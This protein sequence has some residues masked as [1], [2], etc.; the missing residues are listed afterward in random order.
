MNRSKMSSLL[1]RVIFLL[2][3]LG[4]TLQTACSRRGGSGASVDRFAIEIEARLVHLPIRGVQVERSKG[5]SQVTGTGGVFRCFLAEEISFS[6]AGLYLGSSACSDFV[7][8][9]SLL[10][11]KNISG[12]SLAKVSSIIQTFAV[13]IPATGPAEELDLGPGREALIAIEHADWNAS[14]Y[15][16]AAFVAT[17]DAILTAAKGAAPVTE[18]AAFQAQTVQSPTDA[19]VESSQKSRTKV[20]ELNDEM[21]S[22]HRA[23]LQAVALS[24]PGDITARAKLIPAS[25][26]GCREEYVFDLNLKTI[27]LGSRDLFQIEGFTS[28]TSLGED[29]GLEG[30][31]TATPIFGVQA[32]TS[33][34][35][36]E[37]ETM[38]FYLWLNNLGRPEGVAT[39]VARDA[40]GVI[41]RT[42]RYL[43]EVN[44]EEDGSSGAS[45]IGASP[46]RPSGN[47]TDF[48]RLAATLPVPLEL[49][50]SIQIGQKIY[51]IGGENGTVV[52]DKIYE[53]NIAEDGS[54]GAFTESAFGIATARKGAR[55][56]RIGD[57]VYLLGGFTD[58]GSQS[59]AAP[60]ASIEM[61]TCNDQGLTSGFA[62][63]SIVLD[64]GRYNFLT[65]VTQGFIYAL[66]GGIDS[67]VQ[68]NTISRAPL[69]TTTGE[70]TANFAA[71]TRTEVNANEF[72]N[73]LVDAR[74]THN[75]IRLGNQFYILGGEGLASI[76]R[77]QIF[78]DGSIGNF[79]KLEESLTTGRNRLSVVALNDKVYVYGG[80]QGGFLTAIE[81]APIIG[82]QLGNFTVEAITLADGVENGSALLTRNAMYLFGGY[83]GA[84]RDWIQRSQIE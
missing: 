50:A 52:T 61:A 14:L 73:G 39:L 40:E 29:L 41:E 68:S 7:F 56:E 49:A 84:K 65:L 28:P 43:V 5:E 17:L 10:N 25:C 34:K 18:N 37:N 81:S 45:T 4:L 26:S 63:T 31:D 82:N 42:G 16:D 79:V 30:A 46:V 78:R 74:W 23:S 19:L 35:V 38:S 24:N 51:L 44:R 11:A 53:A 67:S 77:V 21:S 58:F 76:E 64:R 75:G 33:V 47:P 70:I 62:A 3:F 1:F 36:S 83:N 80:W 54:I 72:T 2:S 8:V 15:A 71:L 9:T 60:L 59:S 22:L 55:V 48:E 69:N 13:P 20:Q 12:W 32:S 66:G 57:R 27:P 6:V